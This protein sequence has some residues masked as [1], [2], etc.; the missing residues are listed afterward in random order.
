MHDMVS[1]RTGLLLLPD[2]I[3]NSQLSLPIDNGSPAIVIFFFRAMTEFKYQRLNAHVLYYIIDWVM[4]IRSNTTSKDTIDLILI[5][6]TKSKYLGLFFKRYFKLRSYQN[7]WKLVVGYS[8]RITRITWLQTFKGPTCS[9]LLLFLIPLNNILYPQRSTKLTF[10]LAIKQK[11]KKLRPYKTNFFGSVY[12]FYTVYQNLSLCRICHVL[13]TTRT[14]WYMIKLP[15]F[16]Y[17]Y[18][19]LV[20]SAHSNNTHVIME[21]LDFVFCLINKHKWEY[22]LPEKT[23]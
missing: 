13:N 5:L 1:P 15:I 20:K 11:R 17:Y 4:N 6:L 7:W 18:F 19:R 3:L 10:I 23:K 22:S 9:T 8:R 14:T 2:H 16:Y 12:R 21:T